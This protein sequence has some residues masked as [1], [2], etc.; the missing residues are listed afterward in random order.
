MTFYEAL[1]AIFTAKDFID[2]ALIELGLRTR[3]AERRLKKWCEL[4]LIQ[5]K[6]LG[7]YYKTA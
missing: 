1:P 4:K 7:E 2:K 5:K 6:S 3:T